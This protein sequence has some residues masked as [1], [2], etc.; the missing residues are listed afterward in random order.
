MI[1]KNATYVAV[2]DADGFSKMTESKFTKLVAD[3]TTK[4]TAIQAKNLT[5]G[6]DEQSPLEEVPQAARTQTF[7]KHIA[8]T[9]ADAQ[10]LCP[11]E[12]VL[13]TYFNRGYS[14]SEEGEISDQITASDFVPVDG[15]IDLQ[16]S[17]ATIPERTRK[18]KAVSTGEVLTGIL[19]MSNDQLAALNLTPDI[20]AQLVAKFSA[21]LGQ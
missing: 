9:L 1:T 21:V 20:V 2:A 19:G 10:T 3:A 13:I 16:A 18:T 15:V 8:E 11:D 14:L 7:V 5:V 17:L 4:N 12:K 6:P